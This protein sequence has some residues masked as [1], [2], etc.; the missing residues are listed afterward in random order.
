MLL[1]RLPSLPRRWPFLGDLSPGWPISVQTCHSLL[2][3]NDEC[4]QHVSLCR[5]TLKSNSSCKCSL[6]TLPKENIYLNLTLGYSKT[7]LTVHVYLCVQTY[8]NMLFTTVDSCVTHQQ[9]FDF[10]PKWLKR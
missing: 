7:L 10:V 1:L 4:I 6:S 9:K 5:H 8:L 3:K 2:L